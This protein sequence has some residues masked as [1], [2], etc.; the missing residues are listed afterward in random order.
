MR[1]IKF[2]LKKNAGVSTY[3]GLIYKTAGVSRNKMNHSEL[4][5]LA[6]DKNQ[7]DS[8]C[9]FHLLFGICYGT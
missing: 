2:I 9:S 1:D 5:G 7:M 4:V 8:P 3:E 6:N